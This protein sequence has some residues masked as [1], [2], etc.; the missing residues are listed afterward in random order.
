MAD[1]AAWPGTLDA[2]KTSSTTPLMLVALVV[3]MFVSIRNQ[4]KWAPAAT[5]MQPTIS[6]GALVQSDSGLLGV[7]V[8]VSEDD[9]V[10]VEIEPGVVI[11]W[12]RVAIREVV[13]EVARKSGDSPTNGAGS[14]RYDGFWRS[15]GR[16]GQDVV[17]AFAGKCDEEVG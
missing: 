17:S 7:V 6:P 9:A 16:N 8:D 1:V 15:G 11:E 2:M 13:T 4:K 3:L 10:Y 12:S 5:Y 14:I